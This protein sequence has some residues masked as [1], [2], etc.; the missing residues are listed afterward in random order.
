M[1]LQ[2]AERRSGWNRASIILRTSGGQER[3]IVGV[4]RVPA[5]RPHPRQYIHGALF[6]FREPKET[7]A[8][9]YDLTSVIV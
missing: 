9:S 3:W 8:L 5:G 4:H 2:T 1:D 6:L 7:A